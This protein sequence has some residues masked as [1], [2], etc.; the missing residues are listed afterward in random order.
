MFGSHFKVTD[1][2]AFGKV[3]VTDILSVLK[4]EGSSWTRVLELAGQQQQCSDQ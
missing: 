4:W 3:S 1:L 2:E